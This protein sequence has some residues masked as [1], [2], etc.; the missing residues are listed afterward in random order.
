MS[1]SSLG[2][3]THDWREM[4]Q[5]GL[6]IATSISVGIPTTSRDAFGKSPASKDLSSALSLRNYRKQS[7]TLT[8][9]FHGWLKPQA[10]QLCAELTSIKSDFF[11]VVGSGQR[12]CVSTLKGICWSI[13]LRHGLAIS[14]VL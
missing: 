12:V 5:R 1:K 8:I 10:S 11:G 6:E 14:S 2:G 7:I 4:Y 13:L 9:L 3:S